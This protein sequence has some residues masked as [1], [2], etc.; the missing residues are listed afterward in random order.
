MLGHGQSQGL[1]DFSDMDA[2]VRWKIKSYCPYNNPDPNMHLNDV[3]MLGKTT[4][5]TVTI[6]ALYDGCGDLLVIGSKF[7]FV[8]TRVLMSVCSV[9]SY[10]TPL[11]QV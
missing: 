7:W 4:M 6:G 2:C 5:M 8:A 3:S 9:C 10:D 11:L 1:H